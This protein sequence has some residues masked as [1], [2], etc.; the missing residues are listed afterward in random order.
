ML[1]NY[2]MERHQKNHNQYTGARGEQIAADYLRRKGYDIMA[3]NWRWQRYEVDVVARKDNQLVLI[4]VKTRTSARYGMPEESV[5][6]KKQQ[7]LGEAAEVLI[8]QLQHQGEIRFDIISV[9]I[10]SHYYE[11]KHFEDAFFPYA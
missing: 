9:L 11:I 7:Q 8:Q 1:Q 5:S 6:E 4:E 2:L 10:Y 3:V